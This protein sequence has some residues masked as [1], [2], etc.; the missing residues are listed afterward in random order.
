[1]AMMD[2]R[3]HSPLL[4]L[5][6]SAFL[7]DSGLTLMRRVVKR[8]RWWTA[9][10][11]HAYQRW[12]CSSGSH[13][14]VTFMY[15]GWTAA[16]WLLAWWLAARAGERMALWCA[17]WFTM[18]VASWAGLQRSHVNGGGPRTAATEKDRK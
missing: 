16:S 2:G 7:V 12:A 14:I 11:Q 1:M 8:E 13:M 17:V 6:L 3:L 18:A 4:L 10:A 5:P 9:H 15:A